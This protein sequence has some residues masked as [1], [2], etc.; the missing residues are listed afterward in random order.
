MLDAKC[1]FTVQLLYRLG[2]R[3]EIT[4]AQYVLKMIGALDSLGMFSP[5]ENS[6]PV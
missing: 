1:D 6:R 3:W 5:Q 2:F 4:D